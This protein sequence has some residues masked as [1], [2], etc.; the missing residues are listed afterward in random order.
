[1]RDS[2][3]DALRP[4]LV[5]E[6]HALSASLILEMLRGAC[7]GRPL[8]VAT[9][10]SQAVCEAGR[11]QP[12]LLVMDIGL[13]DS[14]GLEA[15]RRIA[16]ANSVAPI[17]IFSM[18]DGAVM[19]AAASAAGA[20]AFVSKSEPGQLLLVIAQLLR[21]SAVENSP[22]GSPERPTDRRGAPP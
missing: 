15:T 17:V 5:V 20:R 2:D 7:P 6:D 14:S 18:H 10:A 9:S 8:H 1:M 19:R 16:A 12:S 22:Q 11:L 13:P 4:I 3:T 21:A